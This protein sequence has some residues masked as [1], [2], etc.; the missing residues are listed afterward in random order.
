VDRIEREVEALR[1]AAEQLGELLPEK[2]RAYGGAHNRQ[3]GVWEA[4][5]EP[6]KTADG[7]KYLIPRGAIFVLPRVTRIIDRLCRIIAGANTPDAMGEEPWLDLAGDALAGMV[8]PKTKDEAHK[9]HDRDLAAGRPPEWFLT[10]QP[11]AAQ[12]MESP[13]GFQPSEDV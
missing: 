5:L 9:Y 3:A 1:K 4:L 2:A 13:R 11:L 10:A 12:G 6:F 8:M 7:Q